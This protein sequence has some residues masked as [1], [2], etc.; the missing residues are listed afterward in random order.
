MPLE[1]A[2]QNSNKIAQTL[3]IRSVFSFPVV[4]AALLVLLTVLTVRS[5][6]SDSDLWWH[7]KTGELIWNTHVIPRVDSF[8][9]TANGHPWT[10]QEWLSELSIYGFWKLG[11]NTG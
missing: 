1:V 5:R 6:F 3:R 9:F 2:A 4:L 8:S 7:L 11:A 10:A